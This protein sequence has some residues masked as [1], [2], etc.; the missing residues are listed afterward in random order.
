VVALVILVVFIVATSALDVA[1]DVQRIGT[2]IVGVT[3]A[4]VM[5]RRAEARE[6]GSG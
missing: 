6:K 1:N 2:L 3:L 4:V 5:A